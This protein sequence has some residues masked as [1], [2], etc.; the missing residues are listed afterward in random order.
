V[1]AGGGMALRGGR[2]AGG[3]LNSLSAVESIQHC[4]PKAIEQC[5]PSLG[6]GVQGGSH[7]RHPTPHWVPR[8]CTKVQRRRRLAQ[9]PIN[10]HK[11]SPTFVVCERGF[12]V[13]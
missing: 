5:L 11:T 10:A 2:A 8:A 1:E 7:T 9:S 6:G 3:S 4:P 12:L 13:V